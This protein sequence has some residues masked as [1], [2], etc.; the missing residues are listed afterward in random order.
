MTDDAKPY[1]ILS[2][3]EGEEY[4]GAGTFEPHVAVQYRSHPSGAVGTVKIHKRNF[5]S[6]TVHQHIMAARHHTE[7]VAQL[8][9]ATPPAA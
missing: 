8:P 3:R 7:A 9:P 6:A 4:T 5:N 2:Q 1:E